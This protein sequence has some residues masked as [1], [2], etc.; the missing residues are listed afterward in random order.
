MISHGSS[1]ISGRGVFA[2]CTIHAGELIERVPV[3]IIPASQSNLI[4]RTVLD[5]YDYAWGRDGKER[6]IALGY[7]SLYNHSYCPNAH[8]T[9]HW[10]ENE[11][12]F[13]ALAR[14]EEG[15]EITINYNGQ[16]ADQ[17]S[18]LFEGGMWWTAAEVQR[19]IP[20]TGAKD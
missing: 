16:P 13:V 18:I 2:R 1:P 3:I 5:A 10:D 8:Y 15:E 14:I 17:R 12:S 4:S 9:K 7:G 11:I 6:A 19:G 20:W